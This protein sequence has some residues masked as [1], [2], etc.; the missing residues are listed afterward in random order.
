MQAH[1]VLE[2]FKGITLVLNGDAPLIRAE[3]IS[4]LLKFHDQKKAAATILTADIEKPSHY[5]RILR[6]E[7]SEV[8]GIIE[9]K[10]ASEEQ[11]KIKEINSGTY[12]FDNRILFKVLPKLKSENA[13]KEYY[14]TDVIGI[15]K[16][17][18]LPVY[19]YKTKN[20]NEI[21]GVNTKEELA[22]LEE[23]CKSEL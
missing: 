17:S 1:S 5:G 10:D 21:L 3:T 6:D 23:L 20:S 11:L 22:R 8:T 7:K 18:R 9:Q 2:G 19:A 12:C 16:S 14:L 13:Q 4:A 15:L